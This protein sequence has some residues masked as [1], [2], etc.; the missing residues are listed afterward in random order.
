MNLDRSVQYP[1][2]NPSPPAID[3]LLVLIDLNEPYV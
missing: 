2:F 3:M 1:I